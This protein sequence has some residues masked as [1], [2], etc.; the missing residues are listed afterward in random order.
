M[1]TIVKGLRVHKGKQLV[2]IDVDV[3][4]NLRQLATRLAQRAVE[5]KSGKAKLADGLIIVSVRGKPPE[6]QLTGPALLASASRR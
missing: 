6:I 1:N 5:N 2:E 4:I 3:E